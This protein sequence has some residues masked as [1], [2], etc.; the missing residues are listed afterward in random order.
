MSAGLSS[1]G[2]ELQHRNYSGTSSDKGHSERRQTSQ[3]S[4]IKNPLTFIV[5]N[6]P[7]ATK[8]TQ[9]TYGHIIICALKL[10]KGVHNDELLVTFT[11]FNIERP[12]H[13]VIRSIFFYLSGGETTRM[14]EREFYA[15][16]SIHDDRVLHQ[17]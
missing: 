14:E 12:Y 8:T 6:L 3:Q 15:V 13:S 10:V 1:G 2:L 11:N 4:T 16:G 7:A 5:C 9:G 17:V